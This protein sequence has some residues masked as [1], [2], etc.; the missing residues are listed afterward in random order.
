MDPS[1]QTHMTQP[2]GN[3]AME[4]PKR[5]VELDVLRGASALAVLVLH[6]SSEP[7][8]E[9]AA[10]GRASWVFLVPNVIAR[11]AVPVFMML[12]GIGLTLS[13][14]RD[15]SYWRFLWRRAST[16]V[17][18]YVI[19]TLIYAWL[20]PTHELTA[21][22]LLTDLLTGHAC[23]HLYFVPAL[24]RLYVLY[25]VLSAVARSGVWAVAA[26][27][28]LSWSMI[29]L[30]EPLTSTALG[31]VVD[32][33]LPL[34]WIGYFVLGIWLANVRSQPSDSRAS[35]TL[36]RVTKL[37]PVA[38]V[39]LFVSMLAIVRTVVA[40]TADIEDALGVAEPLVL[41]YSV[42]VL[43]WVSSRA[44][45]AGP[46]VRF[47]SFVSDR[48]YDVYLSH[49]LVLHV[50]TLILQAFIDQPPHVVLFV[51]GVLLGTPLALLTAMLSDAARSGIERVSR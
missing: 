40:E 28:A 13:S 48:S 9:E 27:C 46:L 43:L 2:Q 30:S 34:R 45:G 12:S 26:S 49:M 5:A 21:S 42:S 11:F 38:A 10:S 8:I 37:M 47:L 15:E 4:R 18:A 50:C 1:P 33:V 7:L 19:W 36:A 23:K 39:V 17:P 32:E 22:S 29:W 6:A 16:V 51:T 31:V 25:P 44:F 14:H 24:L 35:R 3:E 41:P 20:L